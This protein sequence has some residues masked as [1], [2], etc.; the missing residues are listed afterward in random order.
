MKTKHAA[1]HIKLNK[2]CDCFYDQV[3]LEE[4]VNLPKGNT[5]SHTNLSFHSLLLYTYDP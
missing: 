1:W 4:E 5:E 2:L 3:A